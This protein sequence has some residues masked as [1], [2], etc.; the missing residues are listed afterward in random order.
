[1]VGA[2]VFVALAFCVL[3]ASFL[4]STGILISEFRDAEWRAMLMV[5]SHLFFFLPVFGL[6][7]LAAFYRPAVGFPHLFWALLP[8]GKLCYRLG[9]LSVPRLTIELRQW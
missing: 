3:G 1:M 9:V 7:V 2:R 4:A 5:H 6:L 8:H